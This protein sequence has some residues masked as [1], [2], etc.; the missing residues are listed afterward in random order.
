MKKFIAAGLMLASMNVFSQSYLILQNGITL[1]TDKAGFI[2]DFGHF[3]APYKV[4]LNGGQFHVE[5]KKLSTV[6]TQGFLYEKTFKVEKVKGKG[7]NYL[8][9]DDNKLV[10]IDSK[11]FYYEFDKES[12]VFKKAI[13]FGGNFFLVKP[14]DRKPLVDLYTVNDKGNYFKIN[15]A[16]LNPAEITTLGGTF[17]QTRSGVTYTVSKDGFVYPKTDLKVAAVKKAGGNFFIDNAG[18]LFTV[19]ED[20][21]L[22]LPVLPANIKVSTVQKVGA[23]YMIDSEGRV[24]VVDKT[25]AMHERTINHDLLSTKILSI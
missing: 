24:F 10:T 2:Y 15:V 17:F 18:L 20:G 25:G 21:F 3:R 16:G 5:D 9:N 22:M 4:S 6:D 19:S 14:D 23:N 7:L 8:I 1:T 11:G 12:K 13:G